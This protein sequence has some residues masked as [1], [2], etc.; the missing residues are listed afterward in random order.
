[1]KAVLTKVKEDIRD[2]LLQ[3]VF[4]FLLEK[5]EAFILE[6]H[7]KNKLN[8]YFVKVLFNTAHFREDKFHRQYKRDRE[9][10]QEHLPDVPCDDEPKHTQDMATHCFSIVNLLTESNER[11]EWYNSQLLKLYVDLGTYQAVSDKTGIAKRSVCNAVHEARKQV[12]AKL[13]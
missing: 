11:N 4:V 8:A 1:M 12:K 3:H 9:I 5:E 2:D 7:A 6:L 10:P 13:L